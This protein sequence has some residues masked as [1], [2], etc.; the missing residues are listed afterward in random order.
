M[1]TYR[2]LTYRGVEGGI[3]SGGNTNFVNL[4]KFTFGP[5]ETVDVDDND[6]T[7]TRSNIILQEGS[8]GVT[9]SVS[10]IYGG[11]N[12]DIIMVRCATSITLEY[13]NGNHRMRLQVQ[14]D[15]LVTSPDDLIWFIKDQTGRWLELGRSINS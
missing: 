4:R 2:G 5:P 1:A 15:Y 9:D 10:N 7:I 13:G 6:C 14:N 11:A 12:G 8:S 3:L